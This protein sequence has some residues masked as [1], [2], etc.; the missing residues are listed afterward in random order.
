MGRKQD[1]F[2][3]SLALCPLPLLLL[4]CHL[5]YRYIFGGIWFL[6]STW[7]GTGLPT[8]LPAVYSFMHCQSTFYDW[9]W[10][11]YGCHYQQERCTNNDQRGWTGLWII[12]R[13]NKTGLILIMRTL[14]IRVYNSSGT[15]YN[16]KL[17]MIFWSQKGSDFHQMM[18]FLLIVFSFSCRV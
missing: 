3:Y 17:I 9:H 5:T 10:L 4:P 16:G 11:L 2:T 12:R 1:W 15:D 14:F 13:L 8:G 6:W 18:G 7:E